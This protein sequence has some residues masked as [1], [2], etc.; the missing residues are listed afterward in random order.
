MITFKDKTSFEQELQ[1]WIKENIITEAQAQ[2]ILDRYSRY[3]GDELPFYKRSSFII[4]TLGV[5][6][7]AMGVIL[8]ISYNWDS[9]PIGLRF[10]IGLLPLLFAQGLTILLYKRKQKVQAEIAAFFA[11]LM[12]G[13]NIFLQ[14]QIF[15]IS[16]YFPDG[17]LWWLI[18]SLPLVYI[19]R[20]TL[21]GL[22]C[23]L[24]FS[25]WILMQ[26]TFEKPA[27]LIGMIIWGYL[28]LQYL[29]K[30]TFYR[31]PFISFNFL[32]LLLNVF[33]WFVPAQTE[34]A[35]PFFIFITFPWAALV[36]L[37]LPK[38]KKQ[39]ILIRYKSIL[40]V[41]SLFILYSYTFL[42]SQDIYSAFSTFSWATVILSSM[43]LLAYALQWKANSLL[44]H[45][46]FSFILIFWS[47]WIIANAMK[48]N[49][50]IV[51]YICNLVFLSISVLFIYWGLR[52]IQKN[53]FIGGIV[54]IMVLA[55]GRFID[56]FDNYLLAS[57][58]FILC[59]LF[60]LGI[61]RYWERRFSQAPF[62]SSKNDF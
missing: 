61:N 35:L 36:T 33:Y 62:P 22:F 32:A 24:L 37:F 5:I 8:F 31:L 4:S 26:N 46:H 14:A 13:V 42:S 54:G 12:L 2:K 1:E 17:F 20:S 39:N 55:I 50:L 23:D 27:I 18:G 25:S 56:Y 40:I 52:K 3:F 34:Q 10:A 57:F 60:I 44:E 6:I 41:P 59:G 49:F 58:L 19:F 29:S 38:L 16:A 53:L 11:S 21:I 28:F 45:L 9:F 7:V 43:A 30:I 51:G 47:L 15:H 48:N